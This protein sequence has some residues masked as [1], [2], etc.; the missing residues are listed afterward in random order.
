MIGINS[1]RLGQ[2]GLIVL[3][4]HLCDILSFF[5]IWDYLLFSEVIVASVHFISALYWDI[6]YLL[7]YEMYLF[8]S[9]MKKHKRRV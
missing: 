7:V 5:C 2:D 4:F 6:L 1:V 9:K 8:A 3:F